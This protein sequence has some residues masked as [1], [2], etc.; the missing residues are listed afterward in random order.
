MR[1]KFKNK[2]FSILEIVLVIAVIAIIFV[3]FITRA[4]NVNDQAKVVGVKTDFKAFYTAVKSAGLE[5]QLYL[6]DNEEFEKRLNNNLDP[7]LQFK[8]GVSAKQDPWHS[9]YI[10]NIVKDPVDKAFYIMFS[11]RGGS[12]EIEL[13]L[14]EVIKASTYEPNIYLAFKQVGTEFQ[15]ITLKESNKNNGSDGST[16]ETLAKDREIFKELKTEATK[17]YTQIT[18]NQGAVQH[19][20]VIDPAVEP[21]CTTTGLTEGSHCGIC[22]TVISEQKKV[23]AKGHS[24]EVVDSVGATCESGGSATSTC[25]ECGDSFST[26]IPA[27]GHQS[28]VLDAV[29][30][31]CTETGLTEGEYCTRCE[32]TVVPQQSIPA[33]GHALVT[34]EAIAATCEKAGLTEGEH[35]SRC[36]F[37]NAQEVTEALGHDFVASVAKEPTCTEKGT[38][39]YTCSRCDKTKTEP[40]EMLPHTPVTDVAVEPTC[41]ETGL[42]EGT[43]C[44][45]CNKVLTAQQTVK[46]LGHSDTDNNN[47]CNRCGITITTFGELPEVTKDNK[48]TVSGKVEDP[49][50][51]ESVTINGQTVTVNPDGSFDLNVTLT[52][53]SNQIEIVVKDK[54]GNTSTVIKEVERDTT[55]PTITFSIPDYVSTQAYIVSG[56]ATDANGISSVTVNNEAVECDANG[57]FT[58]EVTLRGGANDITITVKDSVGN[59]VSETKRV[60]C[61]T[62]DPTLTVDNVPTLLNTT[63]VTVSGTTSDTYFDKLTI[64]GTT[65]TVESDNKFSKEVSL[66]EGSN[67]I[68]FK[69]TDKAGNMTV[70]TKTVTSDVTKPTLNTTTLPPTTDNNSTIVSGNVQDTNNIESV[71]VNGKPV[72]VNPDGS[73]NTDVNLTEGNN[74]VT[75]VVTDKAGNTTTK[76]ENVIYDSAPPTLTVDKIDSLTGSQNITVSGK[77]EDANGI[78]SVTVNGVEATV[79]PDGTF[80]ADITL[81][82]ENNIIEIVTKDSVGKTTTSTHNITFDNIAPTIEVDLPAYVK[83]NPF[84]IT[85][86]AADQNG[87]ESVTVNETPAT[88]QEDGTFTFSINFIEGTNRIKIIATDKA[89]NSKTIEKIVIFDSTAPVI[90]LDYFP[91]QLMQGSVTVSGTVTD[92]TGIRQVVINGVTV[93]AGE[94]GAFSKEIFLEEGLN[95]IGIVA[96]DIAGNVTELSKTVNY[97]K[98]TP[99]VEINYPALTNESTIT[100]RGTATDN[101]GLAK[102]T[103]NGIEVSVAENGTFK[104]DIS[105]LVEGNNTIAV[106]AT[107]VAGNI[108]AFEKVVVYDK[109]NPT[110]SADTRMEITSIN[111]T[112]IKGTVTDTNGIEQVTVNGTIVT[113]GE[114]GS[115]ST[116]VTLNEGSNT[117]TIVVTDKAGNSTTATKTV[118]YDTTNPTLDV[119]D[120]PTLTN[121]NKITV[122]GTVTDVNGIKSVTVNSSSVEVNNDGTFSLEVTLATGTN[123]ITV[124]ATDKAGNVTTVTKSVIYDN[125]NPDLKINAFDTLTNAG[126]LTIAGTVND[127]SG[128]KSLTI[129]GEEVSVKEDCGF[130]HTVT[131]TEGTNTITVVATDSAGNKTTVTKTVLYDK[132]APTLTV[133]APTGT[134]VGTPTYANNATYTISG[135][136]T[137]TNGIASVT[138]NGASVSVGNDGTFSKTVELDTT[139]TNEFVIVVTDKIGNVT[140][141]TRYTALRI[142]ATYDANGG[143]FDGGSGSE[144]PVALAAGLYDEN[145]NL[146]VSWEDSGIDI[147]IDYTTDNYHTTGTGYNITQV[148]YKNTRKVIMPDTL[149]H[150]GDYAFLNCTGL[151]EVVISNSVASIGESAFENCKNLK[152]ITIGDAV[153]SIDRRAFTGCSN[154]LDITLPGSVTYIREGAFINCTGLESIIIPTGVNSIE[155]MVFWGCSNLTSIIIP[156]NVTSI[157]YYAFKDCNNLTNATFEDTAGWYRGSSAGSTSASIKSSDL[158]NTSTAAKYLK[159]NYVESYWTKL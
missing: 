146:I 55:A 64:N 154:I 1:K 114:D 13:T 96:T 67:T 84:V 58:K 51:V 20:I 62:T 93:T 39:L 127:A 155:N 65:V 38:T 32:T 150:I 45:V 19:E 118:V 41:T 100:V 142:E 99:D 144:T 43:H 133:T 25:V 95:T 159:V 91:A 81:D 86:E 79:N 28:Q 3:A 153:V 7:Q 116:T 57:N 110:L 74:T 44:S 80:S 72:T 73:F 107:D 18:V 117:V 111:K 71:I 151:T 26:E 134:A 121:S 60:I 89:G 2:A 35:C 115:F 47:K 143:T 76:T 42:T 24:Y 113:I 48:V 16:S 119:N 97:D 123:V 124:K 54:D 122:S 147:S 23:P 90:N 102:V 34:D 129:N 29:N 130:N 15:G 140:T 8:D 83:T 138:I 156:E 31:T 158:T 94:D 112:T 152:T 9:P 17:T 105:G 4:D 50:S 141:L 75:I 66:T 52:P 92:A 104:Q 56:K 98:T 101:D 40:I 70:V 22:F 63:K 149:T 87:V 148:K 30:P 69:A 137:D 53:G 61:D 109:T 132:T 27:K 78:T 5:N 36:S 59:A 126:T 128:I 145:D 46:E 68:T 77:V 131:L 106:I 6:L 33:L 103:V 88:I 82:G 135:K 108:T 10:Y 139:K 85:G 136:A 157:G 14:E 120:I 49:E 11:S 21:T 125:G 37:T 12:D